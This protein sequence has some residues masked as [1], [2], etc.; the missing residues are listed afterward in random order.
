MTDREYYASL[1]AASR[2]R[3]KEALAIVMI[4]VV[5]LL[6]LA[7]CKTKEKVMQAQIVHD[8][9]F[10]ARDS[11][12]YRF[13][14]D[15]TVER[16]QTTSTARGDTIFIDRLREVERWKVQT[17]T[18]RLVQHLKEKSDST[19]TK[20]VARTEQ[21]HSVWKPPNICWLL[22]FVGI[23]AVMTYVRKGR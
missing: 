18:V 13:V 3:L 16:Q 10:V 15:S 7:G 2:V 5:C 22:L 11:I 6:M 9:V 8:S 14:K 19:S 21:R 4:A 23:L 12:V 17:D 1:W 20:E